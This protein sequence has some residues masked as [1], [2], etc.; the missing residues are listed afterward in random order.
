MDKWPTQPCELCHEQVISATEIG[1]KATRLKFNPLPNTA[2]S[3]RLNMG[4][5][6][7]TRCRRLTPTER[8]T[9]G[10]GAKLYQ[11]HL[12]TCRPRRAA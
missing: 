4:V 11:L 5:G 2:G 12:Q 10:F 1:R 7:E 6:G 3:Y 8:S 9:T